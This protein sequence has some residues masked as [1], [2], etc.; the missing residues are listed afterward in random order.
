MLPIL[1]SLKFNYFVT[2]SMNLAICNEP[3]FEPFEPFEPTDEQDVPISEKLNL[4]KKWFLKELR[5]LVTE[6]KL[7]TESANHRKYVPWRS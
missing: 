1:Y 2:G 6:V 4:C 7:V 3:S 5:M